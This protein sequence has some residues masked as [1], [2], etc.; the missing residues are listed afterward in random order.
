ML[1][2]LPSSDGSCGLMSSAWSSQMNRLMSRS[3]AMTGGEHREFVM[4]SGEMTDAQFLDFN[5]KWMDAV[6]PYLVD[7]GILGT[8]IDWRGLPIAHSGA[9]ALGL[10]PLNL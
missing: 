7:G 10:N 8:F 1:P 5:Q 9:T 2:I 3:G 4:A 6:L